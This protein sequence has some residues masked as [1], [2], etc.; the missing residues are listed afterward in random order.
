MTFSYN[1]TIE[2][3]ILL[4]AIAFTCLCLIC[5]YTN[6]SFL[7]ELLF[8]GN[9]AR[10]SS[11]NAPPCSW[12]IDLLKKTWI[13]SQADFPQFVIFY[14]SFQIDNGFSVLMFPWF[15]SSTQHY[16]RNSNSI[17]FTIW[18]SENA[19]NLTDLLISDLHWNFISRRQ[20]AK[21]KTIL[22]FVSITNIET[23]P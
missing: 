5:R 18:Y 17:H 10:R 13:N 23:F 21:I 4:L 14:K 19:Q 12:W 22:D 6:T 3:V 2:F 15:H 9:Q 7:E 1:D 8:L 20:N 11:A 16:S